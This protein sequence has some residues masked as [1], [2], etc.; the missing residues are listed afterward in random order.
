MSIIAMSGN[1][2]LSSFFGAAAFLGGFYYCFCL[3]G[4]FSAGVY[5]LI[6][7]LGVAEGAVK[8]CLGCYYSFFSSLPA[9]Y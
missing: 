8:T 4:L 9:A 6:S 2:G 1:Y 3:A 5:C 7:S